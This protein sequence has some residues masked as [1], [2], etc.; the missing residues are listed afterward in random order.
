MADKKATLKEQVR[1][2]QREMLSVMV[3]E[4]LQL[5]NSIHSPVFDSPM[6][7]LGVLQEEMYEVGK[8]IS[9][10]R[11]AYDAVQF[12]LCEHQTKVVVECAKQMSA[13]ALDAAMELLQVAAMCRKFEDSEVIW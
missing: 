8:D 12:Y 5:A 3:K 11:K 2:S 6:E 10:L 9:N 4:E 1:H 7:G 13:Y